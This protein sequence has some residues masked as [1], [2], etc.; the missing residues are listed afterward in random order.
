MAPLSKVAHLTPL[1][2]SCPTVNF[3]RASEE[4]HGTVGECEVRTVGVMA[5][6]AP[7]LE[8]QGDVPIVWLAPGGRGGVTGL[9]DEDGVREAIR[10]LLHLDRFG[11][12][13]DR[14]GSPWRQ[15]A[16]LAL[17]G[18]H[19]APARA[20]INGRHPRDQRRV[21]PAI[22]GLVL[23]ELVVERL[24]LEERQDMHSPAQERLA[25]RALAEGGREG[26]MRGAVAMHGLADLLEVVCAPG[27][28]VR[29][30][31]LLDWHDH[32]FGRLLRLG[33]AGDLV[34]SCRRV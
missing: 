14:G 7:G 4:Q 15:I 33:L 24:L 27:A 6:Q 23:V 9:R 1:H 8:L 30:T 18:R 17:V 3:V 2:G 20:G 26:A 21:V 11:A 10:D 34:S 13:E 22:P 5:E 16:R 19:P 32:R 28:S 12:G 31:R 29:L 25:F